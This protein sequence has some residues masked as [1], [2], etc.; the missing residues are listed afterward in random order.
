VIG[1]VAGPFYSA[2]VGFFFR[3]TQFPSSFL[4]LL[5]LAGVLSVELRFEH[6]T[7][8]RRGCRP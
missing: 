3:E 2:R 6:G 8:S 4:G 5:P 1:G 7:A